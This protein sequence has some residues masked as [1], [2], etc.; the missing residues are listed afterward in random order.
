MGGMRHLA[1]MA[2]TGEQGIRALAGK[3]VPSIENR[4]LHEGGGAEKGKYTCP[5]SRKSGLSFDHF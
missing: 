5:F 3:T 1:V 2:W 4:A